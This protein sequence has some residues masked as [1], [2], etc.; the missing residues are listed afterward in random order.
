MRE[1]KRKVKV[2]VPVLDRAVK[3]WSPSSNLTVDA[4]HH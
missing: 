1:A 4:L 3:S 2:D